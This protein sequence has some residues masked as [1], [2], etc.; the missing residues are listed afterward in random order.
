M[1]PA[2]RTAR[3]ALIGILVIVAAI[4]LTWFGYALYA[5]IGFGSWMVLGLIIYFTY[6]RKHSTVQRAIAAD[7]RPAPGRQSAS[8]GD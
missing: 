6:S 4:L 1:N 8:V 3:G 7:S 5:W 2:L